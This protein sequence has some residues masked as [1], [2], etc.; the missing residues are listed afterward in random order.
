MKECKSQ[1][2]ALGGDGAMSMASAASM[3][4]GAPTPAAGM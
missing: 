3:A 4:G 1:V 2:D